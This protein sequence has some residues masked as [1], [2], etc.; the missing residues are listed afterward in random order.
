MPNPGRCTPATE[1]ITAP[2]EQGSG[3]LS[4]PPALGGGRHYFSILDVAGSATTSGDAVFAWV[5]WNVIVGAGKCVFYSPC[6][7][8]IRS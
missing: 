5:I 2:P 3:P 4:V 7:V 8:G 6:G 1:W